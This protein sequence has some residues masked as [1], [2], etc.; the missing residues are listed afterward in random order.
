MDGTPLVP[1]T[2]DAT[3]LIIL[4]SSVF[5]ARRKGESPV[6]GRDLIIYI[7]ANNLENEFV[8]KDGKFI[9][10]I[11]V[12]EAAAKMNVGDATIYAW[13][14]Q[15]LLNCVVIGGTIYIPADFKAPQI[16]NN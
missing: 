15:G 8:F 12:D 4:G 2:G 13:I 14:T 16:F 11:T 7:L 10:F 5:M 1:E 6:T 9:G 3:Y